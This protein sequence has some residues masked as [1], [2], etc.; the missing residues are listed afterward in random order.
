MSQDDTSTGGARA[1]RRT[2][3]AVNYAKEQDFSGDED[4][5]EDEEED[6]KPPPTINKRRGRPRKSTDNS[7]NN[8]STVR[9][10]EQE[11]EEIAKPVFTEKGYDPTLPPLRDRFPFMPE[12]EADGSPRIEL[13]VGRRPVQDKKAMLLLQQQQQQEDEEGDEHTTT[14]DA[15]GKRAVAARRRTQKESPPPPVKKKKGGKDVVVPGGEDVEYEYLMKYKGKSYLHLTWKTGHDLESMNKSAKTLYRRF[16]KKLTTGTEEGLED[17][18]F[19]TSYAVPQKIVD[20]AEQEVTVELTDKEL[21]EWEKE[22][23]KEIVEDDDDEDD[24]V[25]V[26]GIDDDKPKDEAEKKETDPKEEKGTLLSCFKELTSISSHILYRFHQQRRRK[27]S[28][29]WMKIL[30]LPIFPSTNFA[31]LSTVTAPTTPSLRAPTIH[32]AMATLLSLPRS[33]EH[34]TSSSKAPCVPTFKSSTPRLR[35]ASS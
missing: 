8:N 12:Y 26:E 5:F 1:R 28:G 17:P 23:E 35:K 30:I 24:E 21:I 13:I 20:E 34:P 27:R 11:D 6:E 32:T 33:L 18:E 31:G 3:K 7:N 19:D 25:K 2:T 15:A 10:V 16:L 9:M 22:R 14:T 4:V 29:V